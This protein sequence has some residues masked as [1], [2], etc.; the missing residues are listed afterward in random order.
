MLKAYNHVLNIIFPIKCINCGVFAQTP[1]KYVC[2]KCLGSI[3]IK[4]D[5]ECIGCTKDT[6][7]GST[8]LPC[9]K[10]C[11][12]DQLFIVTDYKDRLVVKIIKL[13]KY[14]F[15]SDLAFSIDKLHRKYIRALKEN[16]HDLFS[17]NPIIIPVPLFKKRFNWRGFNQSALIAH[18]LG[19]SYNLE[20]YNDLL[21]RTETSIPQAEVVRRK[22]RLHNVVGNFSYN[23]TDEI[24]GRTILLVDDICTTGATLNECAKVLKDNGAKTVVGLVVAR[25]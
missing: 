8:C 23:G 21:R 19:K 25:G 22:E 7:F 18:S 11:A 1:D 20:M 9:Q 13:F 4:A 16:G 6:D 14:R 24:S 2:S 12:I 15:I 5:F 3:R 10:N 17:D